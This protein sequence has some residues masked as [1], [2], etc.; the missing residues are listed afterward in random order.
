MALTGHEGYDGAGAG[1]HGFLTEV[2][3]LLLPC[4]ESSTPASA[5]SLDPR[6]NGG[7]EQRKEYWSLALSPCLLPVWP[8]KTMKEPPFTPL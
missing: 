4:R 3:C 5:W 1:M 7:L 6:E 2:M 8:Q